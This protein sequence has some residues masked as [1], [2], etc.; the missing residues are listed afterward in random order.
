MTMT[1]MK[2]RTQTKECTASNQRAQ[3]VRFRELITTVLLDGSMDMD[4]CTDRPP[5]VCQNTLLA[6]Q[7]IY[8]M[9]KLLL[10]LR[11]A[12]T[13]YSVCWIA[14]F[15]SYSVA[16]MRSFHRIVDQSFCQGCTVAV[17]CGIRKTSLFF[18]TSWTKES[19]LSIQGT[20]AGV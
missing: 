14:A 17:W 15:H 11:C 2:V 16:L 19:P 7:P 20:K 3:L 4:I 18:F 10:R 12:L 13:W 1:N 6:R 8:F 5:A 9:S